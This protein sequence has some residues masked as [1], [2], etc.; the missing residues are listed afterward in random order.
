MAN[1]QPFS[2]FEL[3]ITQPKLQLFHSGAFSAILTTMKDT[4]HGQTKGVIDSLS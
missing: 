2:S 4:D 1:I 3:Q